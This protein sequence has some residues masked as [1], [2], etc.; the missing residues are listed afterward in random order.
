[1]NQNVFYPTIVSV[2]FNN[3]IHQSCEFL[4]FALA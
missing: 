4:I 2:Y 3:E 1:M